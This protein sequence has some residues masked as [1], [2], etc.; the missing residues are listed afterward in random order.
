[1]WTLLTRTWSDEPIGAGEEQV[2]EQIVIAME[3]SAEIRIGNFTDCVSPSESQ[4]Y[5]VA[6]P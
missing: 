2:F 3:N 4:Q 1:M 5:F 6:V